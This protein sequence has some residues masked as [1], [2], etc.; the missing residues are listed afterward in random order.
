MTQIQGL[1]MSVAIYSFSVKTEYSEEKV[2]GKT[3][4]LRHFSEFFLSPSVGR[5]LRCMDNGYCPKDDEVRNKYGLLV[6]L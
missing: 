2:M 6:V 4:N 1:K 5:N 3:V